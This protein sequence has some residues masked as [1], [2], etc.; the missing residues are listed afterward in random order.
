MKTKRLIL[1]LLIVGGCSGAKAQYEENLPEF[2]NLEI[3]DRAVVKIEYL[4]EDSVPGR[5]R[6]ESRHAFKPLY[7]L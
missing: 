4:H 3:T 5:I 2:R 6:I 7:V 1:F